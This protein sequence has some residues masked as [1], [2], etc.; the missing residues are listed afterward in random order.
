MMIVRNFDESPIVYS[1][2]SENLSDWL[3]AKQMPSFFE[4][5]EDKIDM[6]FNEHRPVV[7]LFTEG[8]PDETFKQA[9]K[10]MQGQILFAFQGVTSFFEAHMARFAGV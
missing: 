5:K 10:E 7:V 1:G 8:E 3:A 4:M 6:I 9:A 2:D